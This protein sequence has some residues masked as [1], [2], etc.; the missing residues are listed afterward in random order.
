MTFNFVNAAWVFFRARTFSDAMKVL[1][2]MIG[3]SGVT[4][5]KG[6]A[7][8]LAV[9][10][11]YGVTFGDTLATLLWNERTFYTLIVFFFLA[12]FFRNSD[13]MVEQL[14]PSWRTAAVLSAISLY[15]VSNLQK[16]SEFI[17]FN[18]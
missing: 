16:T 10:K 17:Y 4:L 13:E 7:S 18:F 6:L 14:K 2:G 9:L 5:P 11:Q 15:A 1:R 3:L 8:L 12:V